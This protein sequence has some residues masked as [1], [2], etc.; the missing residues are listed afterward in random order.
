[1]IRTE[2][3]YLP[4]NHPWAK[5]YRAQNNR[6]L[7]EPP[8]L[9]FVMFY[10]ALGVSAFGLGVC[11][12]AALWHLRGWRQWL[13]MAIILLLPLGF[14]LMSLTTSRAY[15]SAGP[16]MII[17]GAGHLTLAAVAYTA[18][19]HFGRSI[20][21]FVVALLVPPRPRQF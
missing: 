18:G 13:P 2:R 12:S 5:A 16:A 9:A 3:R 8:L 21:R 17:I 11:Q 10:T 14:L 6:M 4:R 1:A 20:A 19:L 15:S 7:S